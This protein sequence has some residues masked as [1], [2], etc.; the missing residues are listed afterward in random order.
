M[1]GNM[2]E[3]SGE[4]CCL[5][6]CVFVWWG[7]GVVLGVIEAAMVAWEIARESAEL[8]VLIGDGGGGRN[9]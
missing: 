6:V 9:Q 1:R 4:D 2:L 8:V 3:G 7:V 5:R